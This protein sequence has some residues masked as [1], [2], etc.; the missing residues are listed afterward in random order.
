MHLATLAFAAGL[1]AALGSV[2]YA[3]AVLTT[4]PTGFANEVILTCD[5]CSPQIA[6]IS[7]HRS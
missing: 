3:A 7:L 5:T 6:Q 4:D 2:S 1:F